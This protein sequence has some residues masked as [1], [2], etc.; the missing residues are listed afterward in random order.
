[1]AN[2]NLFDGLVLSFD[3]AKDLEEWAAIYGH[4]DEQIVQYQINYL[5]NQS[6]SGSRDLDKSSHMDNT[7]SM[8]VS[9]LHFY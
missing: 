6:K 1:M 5:R 8:K 9:P 3:D 2:S 7:Y 4:I